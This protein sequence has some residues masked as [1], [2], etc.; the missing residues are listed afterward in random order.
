LKEL[1][2]L[3][4]LGHCKRLEFLSLL[5]SPVSERPH[6]RSW[7]IFR[8]RALRVLDGEKVRDS[9]RA[10]AKKL[11]LKSPDSKELSDLAL[12]ISSNAAAAAPTLKRTFVVGGAT[13]AAGG[14]KGRL[15][16]D[17]EKLRIRAAIQNATS[18]EEVKRLRRLLD[19][20]QCVFS[21]SM[22]TCSSIDFSWFS[23]P[24]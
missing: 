3:D 16:N 19:E 21:N 1:K 4:A 10:E 6:Y 22:L 11:F 7:L 5:R 17:E 20:G 8:C 15:L 24:A 13:G 18:L 23:L 9:E 12:S 14:E 2:D